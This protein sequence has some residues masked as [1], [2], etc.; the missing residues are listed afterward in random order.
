MT[1]FLRDR[2]AAT[3]IEYGAMVA[4]LG[5]AILLGGSKLRELAG[6]S[7]AQLTGAGDTVRVT[8]WSYN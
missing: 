2:S 1:H 4:V 6:S 8:S 5:V 7:L 3:S